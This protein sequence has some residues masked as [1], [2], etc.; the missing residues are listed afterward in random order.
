MKQL[1]TLIIGICLNSQ[2][3]GQCENIKIVEDRFEKTKKYYTKSSLILR[4][5][6]KLSISKYYSTIE[7]RLNS[8]DSKGNYYNVGINAGLHFL[9]T[10][11]TTLK[12]YNDCLKASSDD[13]RESNKIGCLFINLSDSEYSEIDYNSLKKLSSKKIESIRVMDVENSNWDFDLRAGNQS[14]IKDAINCMKN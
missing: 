4:D 8:I 3:L 13:P 6:L 10:D 7:F 9:F 12:L 2:V 1:I 11:G 5:D 14:Y